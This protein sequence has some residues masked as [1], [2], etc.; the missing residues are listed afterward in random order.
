MENFKIIKAAILK[1]RVGFNNATDGHIKRIWSYLDDDTK[2][3]YL[4]TVKTVKK[5]KGKKQDA[6]SDG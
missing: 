5:P 1:N 6:N 2:A 3:A 4:E